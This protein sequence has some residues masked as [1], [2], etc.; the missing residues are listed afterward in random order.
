MANPGRLP[1]LR[2]T[3]LMAGTRL[4]MPALEQAMKRTQ[5]GGT[6]PQFCRPGPHLA[7]TSPGDGGACTGADDEFLRRPRD[8]SSRA[9][10]QYFTA[11]LQIRPV[12][13]EVGQP[14][15][16]MAR[17]IQPLEV[18]SS[19]A[20]TLNRKIGFTRTGTGVERRSRPSKKRLYPPAGGLT[21]DAGRLN[22]TYP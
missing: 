5:A 11:R 19:A 12:K 13:D 16:S 10:P 1:A 4:G 17:R 14:K 21:E 20:A 7:G 18:S 6:L 22:K 8:S 15:T 9:R 2:A 3:G